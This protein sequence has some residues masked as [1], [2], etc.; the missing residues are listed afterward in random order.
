MGVMELHTLPTVCTMTMQHASILKGRQMYI[1]I[2]KGDTCIEAVTIHRYKKPCLCITEGN[3]MTKYASFHSKE[4]A[5]EFMQLLA[6]FI[7]Q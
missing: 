1:K 3:V 2:K 5:E 4:A 7:E 6:E